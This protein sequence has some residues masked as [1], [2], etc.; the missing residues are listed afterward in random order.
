MSSLQLPALK[1]DR[2]HLCLD[3]CFFYIWFLWCLADIAK[4][5]QSQFTSFY[6]P[7][8]NAYWL[9]PL[10]WFLTMLTYSEPLL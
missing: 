1:L 6:G 4:T 9:E 8:I 7:V 2:K 3:T 5:V 10:L